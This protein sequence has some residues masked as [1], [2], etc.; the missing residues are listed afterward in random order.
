M[1]KLLLAAAALLPLSAHAQTQFQ[2]PTAPWAGF[3]PSNVECGRLL[4]A[5]FNSTADQAIPIS[6]PTSLYRIELI[7]VNN[8]STSMTT[9]QGGFYQTTSKGGTAIVANNTAYTTLT[10][11]TPDT[12]GSAQNVTLA[13]GMGNV[14]YDLS[15]IYFSLTTAQGTAATADIRVYCRPLY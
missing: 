11:N 14:A 1:R 6:V 7:M 4:G 15:T 3:A 13:S 12:T 8:P 9:A 5:N 2:F 10:T